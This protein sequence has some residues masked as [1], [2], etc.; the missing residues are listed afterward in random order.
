MVVVTEKG[1]EIITT[2]PAEE[3][4]PVGLYID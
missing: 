2:W 3:I 4:I 1:H